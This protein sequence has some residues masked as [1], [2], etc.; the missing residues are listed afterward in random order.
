[1]RTMVRWHSPHFRYR[2]LTAAVA[3]T[4][5][6]ALA[7]TACSSAASSS[8]GSSPGG[9]AA[10][11]AGGDSGASQNSGSSGALTNVNVTVSTATVAYSALY[12]AIANG[13]FKDEGLNVTITVVAGGGATIPALLSNSA[14]FGISSVF[15]QLD[16]A[17]QG[18][19]VVSIGAINI[20]EGLDVVISKKKAQ[21]LGITP[22]STLA[23]KG[24][25]L[26]NLT[27]GVISSSGEPYYVLADLAKRGGV[28]PSQLKMQDI[29]GNAAVTAFKR[30]E[31]DA[32]EIGLPVTTEVLGT[33]QAETL[34][35]CANGDLPDLVGDAIDTVLANPSYVSSHPDVAKHFLAAIGKAQAYY[36]S[37]PTQAGAVLKKGY[38][39]SVEQSV[40][41]SAWT[42]SLKVQPSTP[43]LTVGELQRTINFVESTSGKKVDATAASLLGKV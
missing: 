41:D 24:A 22:N 19:H 33:G 18:Q 9:G 31:I 36:T 10:S 30:G 27:V 12:L 7:V 13:Y 25:A 6:A 38:F 1:M 39:Q 20:G 37:N 28:D 15:H 35:S 4:A 3:V 26:K 2:R 14:Q 23:Q 5:A 40:Y 42:E 21:E 17:A 29:T 34:I 8:P 32:V 16:A 43:T 11:S